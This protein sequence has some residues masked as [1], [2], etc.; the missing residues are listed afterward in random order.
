MNTPQQNTLL[1]RKQVEAQTGLRR[2]T[3]YQ[4]IAEGKFPKPVKLGTRSVAWLSTEVDGWIA[5]RI[6]ESRPNLADRARP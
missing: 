6:T 3:I 5:A 1:R 2:S 4:A